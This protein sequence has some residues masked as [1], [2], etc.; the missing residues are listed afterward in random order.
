M[1]STVITITWK[2]DTADPGV[3]A[4][5][6]LLLEEDELVLSALAGPVLALSKD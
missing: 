5:F 2:E 3:N 4:Y 6:N 1:A